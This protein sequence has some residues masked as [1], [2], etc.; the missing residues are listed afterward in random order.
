MSKS[1]NIHSG[2]TLIELCIVLAILS[3]LAAI[4]AL[5]Y[6]KHRDDEYDQEALAVM[7]SIHQQA[8]QALS[9]WTL[10]GET[11]SMVEFQIP[12]DCAGGTIDLEVLEANSSYYVDPETTFDNKDEWTNRTIQLPQ[13]SHHWRYNVCFG[14]RVIPNGAS[15]ARIP[16]FDIVASRFTGN[17]VDEKREIRYI[18]YGSGVDAPVIGVTFKEGDSGS[19]MLPDGLILQQPTPKTYLNSIE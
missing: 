15:P 11:G 6:S 5:S 1:K 19:M 7:H 12:A 13:G 4:A 3:I 10:A 14:F 9:D 17:I 2:F 16:T 18:L 8:S